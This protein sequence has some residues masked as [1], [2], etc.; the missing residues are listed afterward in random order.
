MNELI[1][2]F[3]VEKLLREITEY[4]NKSKAPEKEKQRILELVQE[5]YEARNITEL[6][7]VIANLTRGVL[8][9]KQQLEMFDEEDQ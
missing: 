3:A 7:G 6:D 5:F 9:Q 8:A 4:W 1:G 2:P